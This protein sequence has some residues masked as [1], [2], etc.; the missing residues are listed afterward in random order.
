MLESAWSEYDIDPAAHAFEIDSWRRSVAGEL[1]RFLSRHD[2]ND[3]HLLETLDEFL[4]PTLRSQKS[5]LAVLDLR[6]LWQAAL[7]SWAEYSL[8]VDLFWNLAEQFGDDPLVSDP[9]ANS[10]VETILYQNVR[11]WPSPV[12]TKLNFALSQVL[13]LGFETQSLSNETV[14]SRAFSLGRMNLANRALLAANGADANESCKTRL[15]HFA[16]LTR[17]VEGLLLFLGDGLSGYVD[18]L[19]ES[20][21]KFYARV[22]DCDDVPTLDELAQAERIATRIAANNSLDN[23]DSVFR[24]RWKNSTQMYLRIDDPYQA[25]PNVLAAFFYLERDE[26]DTANVQRFFLHTE[27]WLHYWFCKEHRYGERQANFSSGEIAEQR[28]LLQVI[29]AWHQHR[30]H[31]QLLAAVHKI[32][33]QEVCREWTIAVETRDRIASQFDVQRLLPCWLLEIRAL[34]LFGPESPQWQQADQLA[35]ERLLQFVVRTNLPEL[36]SS[37]PGAVFMVL[38]SLRQVV[39]SFNEDQESA[40]WY[41]PIMTC[42][43]ELLIRVETVDDPIVRRTLAGFLQP[44]LSSIAAWRTKSD[45]AA[46]LCLFQMARSRW[47]VDRLGLHHSSLCVRD[48]DDEATRQIKNRLFQELSAASDDFDSA[49]RQASLADLIQLMRDNAPELATSATINWL[50][51]DTFQALPNQSIVL[52][53]ETEHDPS[54]PPRLCFVKAGEPWPSLRLGRDSAMWRFLVYEG[55]VVAKLLDKSARSINQ[56]VKRLA[57]LLGAASQG[58]DGVPAYD[59]ST[60]RADAYRVQLSKLASG[61]MPSL[62]AYGSTKEPLGLL[63]IPCGELYSLPW[64][65]MTCNPRDRELIDVAT[66][67]VLPSLGIALMQTMQEVPKNLL[68][69]KSAVLVQASP[70]TPSGLPISKKISSRMRIAAD[71]FIEAQDVTPQSVLDAVLHH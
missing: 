18:A 26:L 2:K 47:M 64:A 12:P 20:E 4:W 70:D 68:D 61:L 41:H 63:I 48:S 59:C 28:V 5:K 57:D 42:A 33:D 7:D 50:T 49:D 56:E 24:R 35:K 1:A 25:I 67:G 53:F 46:G 23:E 62:D 14:I 36:W 8:T 65:A 69:S 30:G 54:Q 40:N 55:H 15:S 27:R 16:T 13:E 45:A 71:S 52:T 29:R 39:V 43:R 10:F 51:P 38:E 11:H 44:I 22:L 9:S 3:R 31:A 17:K 60:P 34:R 37:N 58:H 66:I 21:R 32:L 19:E 6:T